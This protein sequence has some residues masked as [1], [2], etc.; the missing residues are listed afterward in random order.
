MK[1]WLT[2]GN[3]FLVLAS[4]SV[5]PGCFK[6]RISRTYTLMKPVYASKAT[7]LSNI[8][9]NNPRSLEAPGKIYILGRYLFVNELDKGVHIIDNADPSNPRAVAFVDIPGNIDIAVRGS[10]LY[11]DMYKE[12]VVVDISDPLNARLVKEVPNVFSDRYYGPAIN[13]SAYIIV[14]WEIK[15]TMVDVEDASPQ[16]FYG[17]VAFAADGPSQS[18]ASYVP[19]IAGSLARFS[20]VNDYLYAINTSSLHSFNVAQPDEPVRTDSIYV[21]WNI[22]TLYPFKDKL[23]IGST[24]GM[25]IYDIQDPA[26]PQPV[27]TFDH[28]RACDPVVTDGDYAF[29]TLRTGTACNGISNQLDVVD[30]TNVE[31]PTL[32]RTYPLTNPAGL[33]KDG[34]TLFICDGS[35][36]LKI[37]DAENVH[38]L[39]LVRTLPD[40]EPKDVIA[41]AGNLVMV[42]KEGIYQ[43]DYSSLPDLVQRSFIPVKIK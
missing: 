41:W 19:G 30:I 12:L 25:F 18:K 11:A 28:A 40:A 21:G 32:A 9:S 6:D 34:N 22:E 5:L 38:N 3:I 7:V 14:D 4:F 17:Y 27:S 2:I 33:A 39:Q 31:S 13:D 36:G 35:D 29:I 23:L 26:K 15:D 37:F 8:R 43:Y 20:I 10:Y 42:A 16:W 1:R 24:T